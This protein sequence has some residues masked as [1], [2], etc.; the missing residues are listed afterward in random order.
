VICECLVFYYGCPNVLEYINKSA[1]V[2]IDIYNYE[3]SYEIIKNAINEDLWNQRI[4]IIR[5]E[6]QKILNK[7]GFFACI[8][9]II[10]QNNQFYNLYHFQIR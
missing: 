6:K 3:K 5:N 10:Q 2:L 7:L 9:K 1:I 4:H 8:D